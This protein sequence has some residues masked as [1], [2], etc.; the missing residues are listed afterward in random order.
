MISVR[1]L[2]NLDIPSNLNFSLEGE[3]ENFNQDNLNLFASLIFNNS[4]IRG[5]TIDSTRAIVD[6]RNETDHRV[7]N[8]ISDLA[9]ITLSGN[10]KIADLVSVISSESKIFF[11]CNSE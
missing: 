4:T 10:F 9:D 5:L 3:G 8:V 6:I 7:I 11:Q 2:P 1:F